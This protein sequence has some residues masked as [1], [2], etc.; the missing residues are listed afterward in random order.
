MPPNQD[1]SKPNIY[2]IDDDQTVRESLEWLMTSVNL[3]VQTFESAEMFL[4][5]L[6]QNSR[7]ALLPM[8]G[9]L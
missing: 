6:M 5:P 3:P 2:I 7:D 9:C 4:S 8:Y 1:M